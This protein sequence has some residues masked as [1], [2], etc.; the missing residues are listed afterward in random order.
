MANPT[1]NL[2]IRPP[3]APIDLSGWFDRTSTYT[4]RGSVWVESLDAWIVAPEFRPSRASAGEITELMKI[5]LSFVHRNEVL[6]IDPYIARG[7]ADQF[8]YESVIRPVRNTF[9]AELHSHGPSQP[10]SIDD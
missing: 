8:D 5:F 4:I 1:Q 6:A 7:E 2:P 9:A 10:L 3:A